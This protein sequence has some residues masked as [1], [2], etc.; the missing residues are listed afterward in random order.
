MSEE[1]GTLA[2]YVFIVVM[3]SNWILQ[4]LSYS[5]QGQYLPTEEAFKDAY[6]AGLSAVLSVFLINMYYESDDASIRYLVITS[7]CMTL[8]LLYST[9]KYML[10][11]NN[12]VSAR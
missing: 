11:I 8:L 12:K 6:I 7:V 5:F 2:A 10:G 1:L 9:L 3:I 4:Y